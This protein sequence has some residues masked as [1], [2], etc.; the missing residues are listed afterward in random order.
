MQKQICDSFLFELTRIII[1]IKYALSLLQKM[2][3]CII[4]K[5]YKQEGT[6]LN[7]LVNRNVP[8]S[9]FEA[10]KKFYGLRLS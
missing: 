9:N 3:N 1:K 4:E 5:N 6:K 8:S 10:E 2:Y 7:S